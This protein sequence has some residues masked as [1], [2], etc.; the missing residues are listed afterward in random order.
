MIRYKYIYIVYN[1][2]STG[3][4]EELARAFERC[5]KQAL[6][7][8]HIEVRATEYAGHVNK[9]VPE[10]LGKKRNV[11]FVSSSGDGGYNELINAVMHTKGLLQFVDCAVLP[12]GNA[13]DHSRTMHSRSLIESFPNV[14]K[15]RL[16]LLK[17]IVKVDGVSRLRYAHSY[18]GLG[19]TPEV[20]REINQNQLNP[21]REA[22]LVLKTLRRFKPFRIRVNK[23]VLK[24]DSLL[25]VNIYQMAKFL[26]LADKNRPRDGK[27][28]VH[29]FKH[30]GKGLLLFKLLRAVVRFSRP[31][32]RLRKYSF[33]ALQHMP[34]QLD[35]E[36]IQVEKGAQVTV[37]IAYRAL[38]TII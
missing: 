14:Q 19:L 12:A 20:A 8:T 13:N 35:G 10:L 32:K 38:R 24:L 5:A 23:K 15:T 21:F 29:I 6:T 25:F 33:E 34:M 18:A 36:V 22:R 31:Q 7:N 3:K 4:S 27:F 2:K 30:R 17:I 11:L 37:C 26:T 16:D 28:E 1:P 9:L